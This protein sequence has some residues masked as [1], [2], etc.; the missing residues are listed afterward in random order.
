MTFVVRQT[1]FSMNTIDE[2]LNKLRH[3]GTDVWLA[4]PQTESSINAL[5]NAIGI[6]MPPSYRNFL[7]KFG[8]MGID[9]SFVSG[10]ID[11]DPVGAGT[12]WLV[13]DTIRFR[14]DYGM[15]NYLLTVHS[16]I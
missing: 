7:A 10:I 5:E 9:D 12:G 1:S 13:A 6:R 3:A 15:P 4:G 16:A 11:G 14:N 8:G 2:L